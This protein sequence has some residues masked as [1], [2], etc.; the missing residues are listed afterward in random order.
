MVRLEREVEE[1][2]AQLEAAGDGDTWRDACHRMEY[3]LEWQNTEL[4]TLRD[5]LRDAE[6]T[7]DREA[8]LRAAIEIGHQS[9]QEDNARLRGL[10]VEATDGRTLDLVEWLRRAR[11]TL[12]AK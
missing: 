1:L 10:L 8:T 4:T 5:L 6:A 2:K 3:E 9:L 11:A 12:E 7:A